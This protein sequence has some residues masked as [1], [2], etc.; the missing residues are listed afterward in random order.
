M[1]V[2]IQGGGGGRT[3]TLDANLNLVPFIDLLCVCITFLLLTAVW[4]QIARMQV[5]QA[6]SNAPPDPNQEPDPV[7]PLTVHIRQ[8]GIWV[9]RKVEEGQNITKTGEDYDYVKVDEALTKDKT[10]Y[11]AE[12]TVMIVT[13]DGVA[14]QE[15]IKV[16]DLTRMETHNYA[17]TLLGAPSASAAPAGG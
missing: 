7:P 5:D 15:M 6:I 11:P 4:N 10:T 2:S 14:Y 1:G 9:G 13:D 12:D 8:D 16:L 17:K 3:R